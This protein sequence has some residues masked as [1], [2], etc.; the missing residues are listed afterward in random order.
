MKFVYQAGLALL[1]NLAIVAGGMLPGM[2]IG[3]E[4]VKSEKKEEARVLIAEVVLEGMPENLKEIVLKAIVTKAG[5][6]TTRS[7]LQEDIDSIFKTGWFQAVSATPS[8]TSKG[9]R[10]TFKANLNPVLHRVTVKSSKEKSF[11]VP[12]SVIDNLFGPQYEKILNFRTL[13]DAISKLTH[14]CSDH[15]YM[16]PK[17]TLDSAGISVNKGVISLEVSENPILSAQQAYDEGYRLFEKGKPEFLRHAIKS[18][19]GGILFILAGTSVL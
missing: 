4:K 17:V 15:G 8:D 7:K 12:E 19:T 11:N 3:L 5:A 10:V 2:P 6:V 13:Q 1:V 9:V 14:W 18:A 16:S